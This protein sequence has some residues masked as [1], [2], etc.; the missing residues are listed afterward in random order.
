MDN[1]SSLQEVTSY[2]QSLSSLEDAWNGDHAWIPSSAIINLTIEIVNQIVRLPNEIEPDAMGGICLW[3]HLDHENIKMI[4]IGTR[5]TGRHVIHFYN[6]SF[7]YLEINFDLE[8]AIKIIQ[9]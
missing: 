8:Q 9:N 5:N 4:M 1:F 7:P 2:I 3:Y 6:H